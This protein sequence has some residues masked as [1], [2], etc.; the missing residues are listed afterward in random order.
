[1]FVIV[2]LHVF[3]LL[4]AIWIFFL[5]LKCGNL[6]GTILVMLACMALLLLDTYSFI[7]FLEM[8]EE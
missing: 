4:L 6:T 1:M 3:I 8:L 2:L 7:M 5:G